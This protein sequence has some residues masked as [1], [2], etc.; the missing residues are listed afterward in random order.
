MQTVYQ[1]LPLPVLPVLR[2]CNPPYEGVE[3][4]PSFRYNSLTLSP[5]D[6]LFIR[7]GETDWNREMRIQGGIVS[8]DINA[9]GIR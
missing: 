9:R 4:P 3:Y 5:M 6:I 1:N 8:I 2:D 7:H